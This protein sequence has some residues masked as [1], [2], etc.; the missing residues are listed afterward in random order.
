MRAGS[1]GPSYGQGYGSASTVPVA[2][3]VGVAA[4][5]GSWTSVGTAER[6]VVR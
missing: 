3:G 4:V 5:I 1:M 2:S 6:R